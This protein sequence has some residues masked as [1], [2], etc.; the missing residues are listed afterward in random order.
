MPDKEYLLDPSSLDLDNVLADLE[1]IRKHIPQRYSMEQLSAI[2]YD[3]P[4][5]GLVAGYK[6]LK[7]SEFWVAGHMPGMPLMPGVMMCEAAAQLSTYQVK[8]HDTMQIGMLGFGGLD[9]VRFRG[10]V[11][12]GD[13]LVIVA[14]RLA[15][16]P[17][18]MIRC[19]FQCFVN[20]SVVCEGE[21]VGVSIPVE[22]VKAELADNE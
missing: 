1:E 5:A 10:I 14:K 3:D 8:R 9:K 6:D 7:E 17:R 12:P 11:R 4:E 21:L 16:R 20:N 15:L 13:R 22:S 19:A 2:V 18:M